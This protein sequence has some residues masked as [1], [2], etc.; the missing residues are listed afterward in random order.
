[1]ARFIEEIEA[2]VPGLKLRPEQILR[3]YSGML[4][5]SDSGRLANREIL[6]DHGKR[7]GPTGLYSVSGVK[8]TTS[9]LVADKV[10][11]RVFPSRV[12]LPYETWLHAHREPALVFDYAW[13]P[14]N[15]ADMELLRSIIS[16]EA[17]FHLSD[18]VLRRTS[19]GDHPARA[20]RMLPVLKTLFDWDEARWQREVGD[21]EAAMNRSLPVTGGIHE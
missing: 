15:A 7:G 18:L 9:R 4:P 1:M 20:R 8:F 11:S 6:V 12:A 17:V 2:C 21:L 10:L 3:V 14:K 13:E 16:R 5:A 19:L